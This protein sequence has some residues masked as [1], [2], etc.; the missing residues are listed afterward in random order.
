MVFGIDDII[1]GGMNLAGSVMQANAQKDA[2]NE[3]KREFES[4]QAWNTAQI[5]SARDYNT[6]MANTAHQR[7]TADLRAAGINPMMTA[8]G[9]SGAPAPTSPIT[10]A[11]TGSSAIPVDAIG[12]GISNMVGSALSA[13]KTVA[14]IKNTEKDSMLKEASAIT[15]AAQANQATASAKNLNEQALQLTRSRDAAAAQADASKQKAQTD[16]QLQSTERLL[17]M[18]KTGS[19]I[20]NDA[21]SA[22]ANLMPTKALSNVFSKGFL[23]GTRVGTPLP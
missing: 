10:N 19:G 7:E 17:N 1:S 13:Q 23:Q 16:L 20:V 11:G 22:A 8:M 2:T 9:G 15:Q 12:K 5:N 18:A 4:N 14:D 3:N 21:S 6:Q